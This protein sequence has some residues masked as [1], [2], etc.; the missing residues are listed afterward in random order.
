MRVEIDKKALY[1][2]LAQSSALHG[3]V[4]DAT[5]KIGQRASSMS[6]GFRTGYYHKDHKSPAVGGTQA[7]YEHDVTTFK[8]LPVGIVHP[9]NYAG[10]KDNHDN[11]TMLKAM[12]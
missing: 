6:A 12:G 4:N 3:M 2:V 8:G 11:N 1:G 9:A 10:M 7:K 5:A